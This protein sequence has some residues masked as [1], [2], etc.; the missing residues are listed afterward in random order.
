MNKLVFLSRSFWI[1]LLFVSANGFGGI[2]EK[3]TRASQTKTFSER[4]AS[5]PGKTLYVDR[6][7]ADVLISGDEQNEII[8]E[9]TVELSSTEPD[10]IKSFFDQ[11]KLV[12]EPYRQ[13]FRVA[14]KSPR[15]EY[16]RRDDNGFRR[17]M[18]WIF[19]GNAENFSIS[20]ELRLRVPASQSLIVENQ[21]GD[22]TIENVN[23]TLQ[24]ENTSGEVLVERCQGTLNAKQ[25]CCRR[26]PRF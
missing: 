16:R 5:A 1:F 10:L 15:D 12:L 11:T 13:G 22:I 4:I 8:A 18:N 20:T 26:D 2:A 21:Y 3:G 23:G 6:T 17:L 19:E 24:V 7:Q 25:L 14:L 9:A